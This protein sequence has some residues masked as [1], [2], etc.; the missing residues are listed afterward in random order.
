M[1]RVQVSKKNKIFRVIL[2]K[3][4]SSRTASKSS[5]SS[6]ST[7]KRFSTKNPRD[8]FDHRTANGFRAEPGFNRSIT[9]E[10]K[11]FVCFSSVFFF[12]DIFDTK[13]TKS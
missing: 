8:F 3:L 11:N 5:N 2:I 9:Y 13:S 4:P 7:V 1:M 10:Y 6:Q 12:F